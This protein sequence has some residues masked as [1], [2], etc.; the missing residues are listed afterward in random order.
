MPG[1][2]A[3]SRLA[4]HT[5]LRNPYLWST[6]W[7]RALDN[8]VKYELPVPQNLISRKEAESITKRW[9]QMTPDER[10]WLRLSLFPFHRR[11]FL[12][13]TNVHSTVMGI[14][15]PNPLAS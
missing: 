4:P 3:R 15:S 7:Q 2:V 1:F 14:V 8:L 13:S 11:V 9:Q 5:E 6:M 10:G 12:K